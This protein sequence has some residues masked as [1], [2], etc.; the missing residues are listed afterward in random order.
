MYS[1]IT[2][3]ITKASHLIHSSGGKNVLKTYLKQQ[4]GSVEY[5]S[6]KKAFKALKGKLKSIESLH[7][8]CGIIFNKKT[9]NNS[10]SKNTHKY[11]IVVFSADY[12]GCWDILFGPI[13]RLLIQNK[14]R[15]KSYLYARDKLVSNIEAFLEKSPEHMLMV[16]SA[17]QSIA[18]DEHNRVIHSNIHR[19]MGVQYKESE[20]YCLRDFTNLC[21][22]NKWTLLRFLYPDISKASYSKV[23]SNILLDIE[24]RKKGN[25]ENK[26][27]VWNNPDLFTHKKRIGK[28]EI[29][30]SQ[31][32]ILHILYPKKK[33]L[34][35]F[36]DDDNSGL[37]F[38]DMLIKLK[39]KKIPANITVK[40]Y[41]YNWFNILHKGDHLTE[42]KVT[43]TEN[44][45]LFKKFI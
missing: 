21:D 16:S 14:K 20:G 38:D 25:L 45:V 9:L 12:D 27:L 3:P 28:S 36:Y 33:I 26:N 41:R 17:R 1:Y 42:I 7:N 43:S 5:K 18:M 30:F 39:N 35:V 24:S 23:A 10:K 8:K 31:I 34:I 2:D 15:P 22:G 37:M 4:K 13:K 6:N 32:K 19:D 40:L 29:L 44:T 11:D